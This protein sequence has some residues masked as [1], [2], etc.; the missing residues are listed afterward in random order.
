M[1]RELLLSLVIAA[2]EPAVKVEL[3]KTSQGR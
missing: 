1:D 3:L 2:W